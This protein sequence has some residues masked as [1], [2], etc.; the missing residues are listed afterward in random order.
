MPFQITWEP[1]GVLVEFFGE[2]RGDEVHRATEEVHGDARFD[3]C[4]YYITDLTGITLLQADEGHA[5]HEA[6]VDKG[7]S[8]SNR[9][10][11]IGVIAVDEEIRRL[12]QHYIDTSK[13][14]NS[15]WEFG[16]FKSLTEARAWAL[17]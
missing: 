3:Q 1:N 4:H 17:R 6:A 16:L 2:C 10:M 8:L 9:R 7:A 11:C 13:A 15:R 5:E 12:A 14:L